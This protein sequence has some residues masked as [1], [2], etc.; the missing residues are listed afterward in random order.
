MGGDDL[1]VDSMIQE[2]RVEGLQGRLLTLPS[3]TSVGRSAAW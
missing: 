2:E 3:L 1:G